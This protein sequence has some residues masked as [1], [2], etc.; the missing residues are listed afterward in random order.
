MGSVHF[1]Q[2]VFR[3]ACLYGTLKSGVSAL[4]RNGEMRLIAFLLNGWTA[5][6]AGSATCL[7]AR[8][9]FWLTSTTSQQRN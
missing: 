9:L 5:W 2:F 8:S 7:S 1:V 6:N 3:G 4:H